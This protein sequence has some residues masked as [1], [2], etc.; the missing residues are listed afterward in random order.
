[1]RHEVFFARPHADT[2]FAPAS[3]VA[4]VRDGGALDVAGVADGDRHVFLGDQVFDTELAFLSENFRPA[5]IAVL[6]LNLPQLVDDDLHHEAIAREDR[7]QPFDQLQQL[8]ELVENLLPLEAG[9]PLQLHVED[10]LRLNRRQAELRDQ[11]I[12]RF[13]WILRGADQRDDGIEVIE[14]DLQ[15]FEDVAA[16][17]GL[18]QLELGPASD[19]LPAELDEVVDQLDQRQHLRPPADD[20]E[21]DDA[22]AALQRGVLVQVVEDDVA[23][24][25]AFQV[26]DD[27]QPVAIRFVANVGN[28]LDRLFA[29]QLRDALNQLRLV[30]L[31][32]NRVDDDRRAFAL[33]RDFDFGLRAHDDH[34]AT[35]EIGLL[36]PLLADDVAAGGEV[37]TRHE[38][39]K[40]PLLL[41]QRRRL[42]GLCRFDGPDDSLD[43]LAHVVRRDVRRH[44]DRDSR[45]AVDEEVRERR[46]QHR[47]LFGR[48]VV[49]GNE[50]DGLLVEIRHHLVAEGFESR[51]GVSHGR[52]W[53]AV[54]R[55][56]V[57]LAV[58]ERRPHVE[59]LREAD[60][61]VVDRGVAVGMEVSHHLADDLRALA[62][63]AA[64]GQAHRLHAVQH[65][66]VRRLAAVARA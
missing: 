36:N 60:E 35:G 18:A 26:D 5:R 58:D 28:A 19:N 49:V 17:L 41:R 65:A 46:R 20:G 22:E 29:Y 2:T 9:Q 48:L 57:P 4:I 53:I 47:G 15:P 13:A 33:L 63:A 61:R 8:G 3:L 25:A 14:R 54:D 37:G 44:A 16:R 45:G 52:R 12:A 40:L 30:D 10:R 1:M 32:R 38:L 31:I 50:I 23:D 62:V 51:L 7:E 24:L 66:A 21:R 39:E 11:A 56:E 27:A 42:V 6:L 55:A 34:A 59:I 64:G 43:H